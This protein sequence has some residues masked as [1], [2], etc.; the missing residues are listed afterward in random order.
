MS[1][2]RWLTQVSALMTK[3]W[4]Q[5]YRDRALLSFVI[6]IF[7]LDILLAS[8]AP[9]LD[10]KETPIGVIDRDHSSVS[11]ELIYRLPAQQFS[12]VPL[13]DQDKVV[14]R[15]LERGELRGVLTIPHGFENDLLRAQSPALQLVVDASDANL[16]FLLS[17]YTERILLTLSSDIVGAQAAARGQPVVI[18]QI[19]TQPR[20]R[21]NPSLTEAWYATL[22][23]LLTM[24]T[25]ACI[26][27][28]AAALVREKERGTVEQLLVSPLSPLQIVL[29]KAFAMTSVVLLGSL[30]A[31]G[32]IMNQLVGVPFVG[33]PWVFFSLIALY[34]I[35]SS[36]LGV[37]ASTFARNSGQVGLI[38]VLLVMPI[39][40]LSGTWSLRESM[41]LWLQNMVAFSP[42]TYFVDMAYGVLLK[43][44]DLAALWPK[45]LK[46]SLLGLAFWALGVFRFQ[47][48]FR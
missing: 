41:P 3:E 24:V 11:R 22:S 30:V 5:L 17:S 25:V 39:I 23:E 28:P 45:A 21:F 44:S 13:A 33:S 6:F 32:V 1:L 34:A 16:G 48:Q 18:P 9:A 31:V 36:G 40:M 7:T 42:M 37:L 15:A 10:L 47:R 14:S 4:K 19:V 46:M 12:V 43:G 8:G 35:T 26:L 20:T 38:V 27:L 2:R 29:A